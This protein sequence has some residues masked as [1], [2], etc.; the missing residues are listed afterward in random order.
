METVQPEGA[1]L[2][3]EHAAVESICDLFSGQEICAE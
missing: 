2:D 1:N 3:H